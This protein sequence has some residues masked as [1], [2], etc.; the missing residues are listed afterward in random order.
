[1]THEKILQPHVDATRE[2]CRAPGEYLMVEDTTTLSFT[3]RDKVGGMGP[4]THK[5]SQGFLVHTNLALQVERWSG[6]HEPEVTPVGLFGQS[7]WVRETPSGT[8]QERKRA[9]RKAKKRGEP[10]ES[11]RWGQAMCEAGTPP[12]DVR[13]TL[14]ADREC[15]IFEVL[16]RCAR[17]GFDWVIRAAQARSSCS[18][19]GDIFQAVAQTP[20]LGSYTIELRARPGAPA[21]Q[22]KVAVRTVTTSL[23]PPSDLPSCYEPLPTS[24]V[25]VCEVDP[26]DTVKPL[27]WVLLTS[28]PCQSYA[29]VRRVIGAYTRR[30][31][32]EEYH[33]ALKTGTHIEQSQ[34]STADRLQALLA[35]HA[36]VAVDLLALKLVANTQPDQP[37]APN[38]LSP[39]TLTVLERLTQRP[40]QGWTNKSAIR[41]IARLG[42]YLGRKHDGPPGWLTIWRGWIKL[43][44]MTEGYLLALGHQIHGQ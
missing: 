10:S 35:I 18:Q 17:Q 12:E 29:Q 21:R 3:Q 36:V 13:W 2:Q 16:A 30:W 22:A 44:M 6:A 27:H 25:E 11:A 19:W 28:W 37:L 9:R 7:S 24:V 43:T 31:L 1:V 42:G 20:A 33:K 5:D 32:I 34:L 39:E 15:D 38:R 40:K 23:L 8:R 26:P 4:L 41:A 14:V